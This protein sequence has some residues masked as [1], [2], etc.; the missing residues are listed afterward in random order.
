MKRIIC[1]ALIL[2]QTHISAEPTTGFILQDALQ[3]GPF[4]GIT[5]RYTSRFYSDTASYV[6]SGAGGLTFTYPTDYWN[7]FG[8]ISAPRVCVSIQLNNA[9]LLDETYSVVVTSN[10][11]TST[12]VMVYRIVNGGFVLEA[13]SGEVTVTLYAVQDLSPFI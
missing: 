12:T 10:S 11:D 3:N 9:P 4:D 6:N 13:S 7:F 2:I 8:N 1:A 5:Q